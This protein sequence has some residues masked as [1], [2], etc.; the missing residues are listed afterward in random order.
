MKEITEDDIYVVDGR[1]FGNVT[2]FMNHSC[3]P[4]CKIVPVSKDHGEYKLYYLAFF[5]SR[6]IPAGE[7]LTFDYNPGFDKKQKKSSGAVECLCGAKE[8]RGQLWP[9]SRKQQQV[10]EG[11]FAESPESSDSDE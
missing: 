4:N 10:N 8:C 9:N 1:K 7:E 2:R 11:S 5:A 3:S 6:D